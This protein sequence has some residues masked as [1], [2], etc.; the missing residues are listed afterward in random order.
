M[1]QS[2][3][4][5][6]DQFGECLNSVLIK[7]YVADVLIIPVMFF[8]QLIYLFLP[9]K[10]RSVKPDPN[11]KNQRTRRQGSRG[12]ELMA[13]RPFLLSLQHL[14]LYTCM[15]SPSFCII[16][17]PTSH[18]MAS[19]PTFLNKYSYNL[20]FMYSLV[21]TVS[22]ADHIVAIHLCVQVKND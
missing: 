15:A 12:P 21:N 8:W 13:T 6:R 19:K 17:E 14:L 20:M 1:F 2:Y 3:K 11:L 10:Q 9:F 18:K 5:L 22:Y 7:S 4:S 16:D